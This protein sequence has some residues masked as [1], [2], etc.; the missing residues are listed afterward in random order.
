MEN[1]RS[2]Q[3]AWS[4]GI[5]L[6][7]PGVRAIYQ[8]WVAWIP[9]SQWHLDTRGVFFHCVCNLKTVYRIVYA[10]TSASVNGRLR[11][12]LS[13]VVMMVCFGQWNQLNDDT[14]NHDTGC[15]IEQYLCRAVK[16]TTWVLLTCTLAICGA[17]IAEFP[18]YIRQRWG[19][20]SA[21]LLRTVYQRELNDAKI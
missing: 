18:S 2:S 6:A 20:C 19:N 10:W 21:I 7:E 15:T 4:E 17:L 5:A 8:Q 16:K 14:R 13:L 11:R 3:H 9:W 12:A 1:D